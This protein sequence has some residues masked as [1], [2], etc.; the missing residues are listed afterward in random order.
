MTVGCVYDA[1]LGSTSYKCDRPAKFQVPKPKM[2]IKFVCGIHARSLNTMYERTGQSI[3]CQKI[4]GGK[5]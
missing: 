2:R 3:R 1:I 5:Q 4:E